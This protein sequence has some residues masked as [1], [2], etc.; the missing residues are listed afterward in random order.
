MRRVRREADVAAACYRQHVYPDLSKPL[1]LNDLFKIGGRL[2]FDRPEIDDYV[3]HRLF[4]L[5]CI[6]SIY[7]DPDSAVGQNS[8]AWRRKKT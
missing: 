7:R 6:I 3:S 4:N 2:L 8:V 5:F 1:N